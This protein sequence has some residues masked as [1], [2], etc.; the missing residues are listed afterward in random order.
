MAGPFTQEEFI[1]V[2][3]QY[4][5]ETWPMLIAIYILALIAVYFVFRKSQKSDR[6]ISII[7]AVFWLWTGLVYHI[8]FFTDINDMAYLFGAL[9]IVEAILLAYYGVVKEKLAFK[10]ENDIYGYTGLF[11]I[12]FALI[13]YPLLG[14]VFGHSYPDMPILPLPCPLTILTFGVL[15]MTKKIAQTVVVVPLIWSI[16]GFTAA[17]QFDVYQD[18]MLLIAGIVGTIFLYFKYRK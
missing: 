7:L 3:T 11:F 9:F 18:V 4:N 17:V 1:D 8:L 14:M 6:I 5:T 13:L 10:Y 15:L 16:I 12:L 2:F